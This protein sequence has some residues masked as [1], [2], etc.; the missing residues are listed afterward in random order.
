MTDQ[1]ERTLIPP[2]FKD[3]RWDS[4]ARGDGVADARLLAPR[5]EALQQAA[6]QPLWVTEEPDAHLWPH[7]RHAIEQEGSGWT[8]G[9]YAIDEDGRLVVDLVHAPLERDQRRAML[10]AD[11]LRLLGM[12][13]EGATYIEI[14]QRDT[15][16]SLI[17][18]VVTG[19]LDDQTPFKTHGHTLRMSAK[20]ETDGP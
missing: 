9:E 10:Q 17:V 11:V 6:E 7:L 19:L 18:D 14:K 8:S 12:V 5:L 3:R 16:D 20:G 4:D 13:I 2:P 1:Q 15:D